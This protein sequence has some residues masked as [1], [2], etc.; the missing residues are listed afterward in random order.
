MVKSKIAKHNPPEHMNELSMMKVH[1]YNHFLGHIMSIYKIDTSVKAI[2]EKLTKRQLKLFKQD[3][4]GNFMECQSF[5]S[6][7]IFV[8]NVLLRQVAHGERIKKD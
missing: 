4:F 7:G 5:L 6:N 2:Q 1:Y 3:I 8:H